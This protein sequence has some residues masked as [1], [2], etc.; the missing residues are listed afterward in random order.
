LARLLPEALA[1]RDAT[2]DFFSRLSDAHLSMLIRPRG[3]AAAAL[4]K[5]CKTFLVAFFWR[6]GG[7]IHPTP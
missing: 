7:T 2:T 1:S 6:G 3:E 4:I 5:V